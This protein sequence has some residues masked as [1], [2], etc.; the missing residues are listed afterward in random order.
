[1]LTG[2]QNI[3]DID[4]VVQWRIKNAADFLFNIRNPEA[5]VKLAS[6]S[7]IRE[8][9]GQTTLEDALARKRTLVETS[10]LEVLQKILDTYGAGVFVASIKLQKVEPPQQV[11]DAFN[12][13]QRARQDKERQ[14]NE[15]FAYRNDIV[16]KAKGEAERMIQEA[17]GYMERLIREAEGEAKRFLSVYEAYKGDKAVTRARLYLERMQQVFKNSEKVIIDPGEGGT[18]VLPYL[19]LPELRKRTSGGSE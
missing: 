18:G 17:T 10:T 1:M 2:D 14:Q 11:I 8:V 19:P 5:T 13:V 7:A 4:Y 9:V 12:D 16:P 3:I 6:E 15:A